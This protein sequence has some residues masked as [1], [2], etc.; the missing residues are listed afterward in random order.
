M[1]SIKLNSYNYSPA[2]ISVNAGND[3]ILTSNCSDHLSAVIDA[4]KNGT[5]S[6]ETIEKAARRVIA[7]KIKNLGAKYE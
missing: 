4:T 7:W 2:I 3:I 1:D 5:I 6:K